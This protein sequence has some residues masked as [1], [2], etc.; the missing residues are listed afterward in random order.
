VR[1]LVS[2]RRP[3]ALA[4]RCGHDASL[5]SVLMSPLPARDRE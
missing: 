2:V 1:W 5:I 4:Y 3:G